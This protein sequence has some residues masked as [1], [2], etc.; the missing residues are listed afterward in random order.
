MAL[1]ILPGKLMINNK[2]TKRV[3]DFTSL[4]LCYNILNYYNTKELLYDRK[5][6]CK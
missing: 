3:G 6:G 5:K 4:F 1:E 2:H